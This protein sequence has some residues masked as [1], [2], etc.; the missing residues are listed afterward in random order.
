MLE[1]LLANTLIFGS[2]LRLP[3]RFKT[4]LLLGHSN[5]VQRTT[6]VK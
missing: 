3:I 6:L 4:G 5:V 2:L 1:S